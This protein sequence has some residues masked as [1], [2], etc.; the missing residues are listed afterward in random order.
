MIEYNV[1]FGD[2]EAQVLLPRISSD[3]AALLVEAASGQLTGAVQFSEDALVTVV[4]ATEGY[5]ES[6]RTG[7]VIGGIDDARALEGVEVFAAGVAAGPNGDL[8]TAGG[9]V[10]SVTGRA[11]T[12]AEARTRAYAGVARIAWPGMHCRSDIAGTN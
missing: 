7:D 9:R 4:C 6:P 12:L 5:P 11:A 2:P 10:L 1:R 8:V 3:L